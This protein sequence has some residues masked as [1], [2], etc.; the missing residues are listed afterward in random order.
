MLRYVLH[1]GNVR[2]LHDKDVH[3]LSEQD[4]ME[5]HGVDPK[6]CV[7]YDLR[8]P[9]EAAGFKNQEGD[10]HLFPRPDGKYKNYGNKG[11]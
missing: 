7:L 8:N 1:P 2:S 11:L 4:L 10:I 3:F 9:F 6:D 5:L